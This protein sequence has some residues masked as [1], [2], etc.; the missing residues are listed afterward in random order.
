MTTLEQLQAL[1]N[2]E[3]V[4]KVAV[5]VMAWEK[6]KSR[7]PRYPFHWGLPLSDQEEWTFTAEDQ[8]N[9]LKDWNHTMEVVERMQGHGYSFTIYL[10]TMPLV[11]VG[12]T[13]AEKHRGTDVP[14][15][16]IVAD[17]ADPSF[18]R[19]ILYAAL[20]AVSE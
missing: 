10:V 12:K 20:L 7:D 16:A 17:V 14:K 3:L 11:V 18:Q 8:W 19:A 2:E 4:E 15:K 1:S 5:E 9:P 13:L 6:R